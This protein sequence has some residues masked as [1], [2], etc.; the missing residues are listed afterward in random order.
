M[1]P[2]PFRRALPLLVLAAGLAACDS[3]E[4]ASADVTPVA[5]AAFQVGA[6]PAAASRGTVVGTNF[7]TAAARVGIVTTVVG[8][9]LV[10]PHEA[11]RIAA[12]AT[13]TV[14]GTSVT[15]ANSA[16]VLGGVY[17][18]T[19]V[20]TPASGAVDW[21]LT[22]DPPNDPPFDLYTARTSLDGRTGTWTLYDG[23]AE[24]LTATFDVRSAS[25]VTFSVPAGRDGA[26]SSVRYAA[27]G[28]A[29]TFDFDQR[30]D[31]GR[32]LIVWNETTHAGSITAADWRGGVRSCWN[33]S[34]NDVNC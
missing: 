8:A 34:G 14:S 11:T 30:P 9:N 18:V 16:T 29:R 22:V 7:L 25:E 2:F 24:A 5:P 23:R 15:F 17:D 13:P 33:A 10:L 6:F 31:G 4:T 3:A 26:G 21:R 19:L 12:Q 20:G 1:T 32:Q 28:D 27:D